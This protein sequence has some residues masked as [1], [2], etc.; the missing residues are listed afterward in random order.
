MNDHV[1][2]QEAANVHGMQEAD[3]GTQSSWLRDKRFFHS[4]LLSASQ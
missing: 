1:S 2:Q 3:I 4:L